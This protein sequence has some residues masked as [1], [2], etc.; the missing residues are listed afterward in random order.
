MV[1]EQQNEDLVIR[2]SR[3]IDMRAAQKLLDYFNL[4]ESISKNQGTE[5]QATELAREVNKNWWAA[6]R[7]R[8]IK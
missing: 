7:S 8:F 5:E 3:P 6:N 2:V 1:V 4:M